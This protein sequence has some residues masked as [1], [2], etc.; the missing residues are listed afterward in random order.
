MVSI[1]D[2]RRK[3]STK[4]LTEDI[5]PLLEVSVPWKRLK[6]SGKLPP[7]FLE[8]YRRRVKTPGNYY[9]SIFE[10]KIASFCLLSG[11]NMI[12]TEDYEEENKQIDFVL[13]VGSQQRTIGLECTSKRLTINLTCK[14]IEQIIKDKAR[15]FKPKY[16]DHLCEKLGT[17][18]DEKLLVIDVTRDNYLKPRV[19]ANLNDL[20][21]KVGS[22]ALDGVTLVWTED[23]PE[24]ED[25]S[26]RPKSK[27]IR[28]GLCFNPEIATEIHVTPDG[29]VLFTRKY[30]EPEPAWGVWGPEETRE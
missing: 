6:D 24:G 2:E 8:H 18:L 19:L 27:F 29:S 28:A 14:K 4:E 7:Y 12:F 10:I 20:D 1:L 17:G 21:K 3:P 15:K 16:I 5:Y 9:G 11:Y 30:V 26:L 22:S 13:Y 23:I 25:H